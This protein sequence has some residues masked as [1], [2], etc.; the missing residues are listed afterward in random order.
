M[1][2]IK[3]AWAIC[4]Q[5]LR[6]WAA[7]YRMWTIAA[8]LVIMVQIYVDDMQK[9]AG[10]LGT[11]ISMWIFPFLYIQ[12]HTKV[13]FTL[14]V[15]LMFCNAPFTDKNQLFVYTRISR[16]KWLLGQILYIFTASALYYFFIFFLTIISTV[17]IAEPSL[18]WGK[19]LYM[20]ANS[21]VASTAEAYFLNVPNIIL[22][23]FTPVQ[24]VFFTF[25]TS[26]L[27]AVL[28]GMIVFFCNLVSNT[29]FIG[30]I[31]SSLLVVWTVL[32][33]MGG[34]IDYVRFSPISWNTLNNID[35]GNMT[36]KPSFAY[37]MCVY[38]SLILMLIAGIFIF[39]RKKSLDTKEAM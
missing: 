16:A 3:A 27:S 5:N 24:A 4:A 33:A 18:D 38:G 1:G 39:G 2:S 34:W 23:Y 12:Y 7:D 6:K 37:C 28:L 31:I 35:V 14:P 21:N 20:I 29:R 17:F 8:L 13:I 11:K 9:V 25:L 10:F 15:L 22:E 36:A 26:W 32:V 30:I 19:T